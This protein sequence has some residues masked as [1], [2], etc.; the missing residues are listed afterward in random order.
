MRKCIF[1]SILFS[2]IVCAVH[3][4]DKK[5]VYTDSA[6]LQTEEDTASGVLPVKDYVVTMQEEVKPDTTLVFSQLKISP[7]SVRNWKEMKAFAYAKY[8]DSL[9]KAKQDQQKAEQPRLSSEPG[10][11]ENVL[12]SQGARVFFWTLAAFF[13]LFI[14]YKLFLSQGVFRRSTATR[15]NIEPTV[16]EGLITGDFDVLI[17]QALAVGNYRLAVRY[18]YLRT[19]HKLADRNLIMMAADKTNYQYVTELNDSR[20]RNDFAS[21]T[22]SYEYVWYGEFAVE[23]NIYR[24]IERGFTGFNQ[25]I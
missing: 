15:D 12:A 17:R 13:I 16:A 14:L 25:K 19:L 5:Y 22:L 23:E 21:L 6:L 18:N 11:L 2:F 4:Q 8:L 3:A 7:D 24:K 10:W 20:Y 1:I 9:L